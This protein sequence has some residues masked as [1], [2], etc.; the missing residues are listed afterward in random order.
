MSLR[1]H[2]R[3]VFLNIC[4]IAILVTLIG[5]SLRSALRTTVEREIEDLLSRSANLAKEYVR[6]TSGRTEMELC[7]QLSTL[8]GVR[9]T[10]I[11][12]D[13]RVLGDS[14]LTVQSLRLV[15]NHRDRPEVVD[16]FQTGQGSSIRWSSTLRTSFVYVASSMENGSV[17]RLAMPLTSVDALFEDAKRNLIVVTFVA[18]GLTLIMGLVVYGSISTPLHRMADVA[19]QL[20]VNNLDHAVPAAADADLDTVGS[21]LN[22]M[23]K[24]LSR[25]MHELQEGKAQMESIIEVLGSGV[26]IF[27]HHC[28]AVYANRFLH[29]LLDVR[30]VILGKTPL[31]LIRNPAVDKA[32]RESLDGMESAAFDLITPGGRTLSVKSTFVKRSAGQQR[33]AVAIFHDLS[34]VRRTQKMRRDLVA[35]ISH[36]LKTPLTSIRGYAETLLGNDATDPIVRKEFLEAI[37]RNATNLQRLVDDML[38]LA[39]LESELPIRKVRLNIAELIDEQIE[40]RRWILKDRGIHVQTNCPA[41]EILVDRWRLVQAVSNILDNAIHYNRQD[42]QIVIKGR[43]LGEFILDVQDSGIGIPA[44]DLPYIFDRFY[45]VDKARSRDA[46][47]SGLGLSIAKHAI[48]S[49]GGVIRATSQLGQGATFSIVLPIES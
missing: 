30:G 26:V 3:L 41:L 35:N 13:G 24:N 49:H 47:G 44:A 2:S 37:E 14:D 23:A 28:R 43:I 36:E 5:I 9:V 8:L 6:S 11:A 29:E 7:R 40:S 15:A 48:E 42:G 39:K 17:I 1:I 18:I 22:S 31:E 19:R 45:R 10:I 33:L 32:I 21:S 12:S 25:R 16:A 38:V 34:E 4:I 46:G 20:A 27:D